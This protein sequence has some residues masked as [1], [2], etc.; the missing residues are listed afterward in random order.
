[1]FRTTPSSAASTQ[2]FKRAEAASVGL[3]KTEIAETSFLIAALLE[4]A[5]A[6]TSVR[7]TAAKERKMA[8]KKQKSEEA[9][10]EEEEDEDEEKSSD[11]DEDEEKTEE[12]KV[13]VEEEAKEE[14]QEEESADEDYEEVDIRR[15]TWG[16]NNTMIVTF[17]SNKL[18]CVKLIT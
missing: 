13:V 14:V 16:R 15:G 5:S 4:W 1:M 7:N 3:I 2:K 6:N 11:E 12:G 8:I 17:K 18:T 10:E 9:K